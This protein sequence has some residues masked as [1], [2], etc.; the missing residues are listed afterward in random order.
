MDNVLKYKLSL[1]I[2]GIINWQFDIHSAMV[3]RK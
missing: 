3:E 1:K 2:Y